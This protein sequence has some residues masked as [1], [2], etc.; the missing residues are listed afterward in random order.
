MEETL[1]LFFSWDFSSLIRPSMKEMWLFFIY[2]PS[3]RLMTNRA[4]GILKSLPLLTILHLLSQPNTF[5][6][7][8]R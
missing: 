6:Q 8:C 5:Y 2:T 7:I 4:G 1:R 3:D